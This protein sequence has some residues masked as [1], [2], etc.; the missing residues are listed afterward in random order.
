MSDVYKKRFEAVF[1]CKHPRGP[2]MSCDVA[3]KYIKKSRAFVE[4]WVNRFKVSKNVDDLRDRGSVGKVTQKDEKKIVTLFSRNP[5]L[6]LRQGQ[7][8]LKQKGLDISHVTLRAHLRA[9][10]LK[11]RST[12]KKPLLSEKHTA[13]RLAW[14]QENIDRDWSNVIFS[15]EASVW[16]YVIIPRAWCSSAK[17]FVQRTVKHPIKVHLWGCFSKKGFGVLLLFTNNLNAPRM[18]EIYKKS[19]LPTAKRQ[20]SKKNEEWILQEDNDPKHR[21]R[22]CTGWKQENGIITLDWAS[23]SPDANPIENVWAYIKQKIRGKRLFTLK[24]LS[25]EIRRVWKALPLEY[26]ENL[27]ESMQRR[28]QAIIDAGGDWTP[29]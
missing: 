1:L 13:K 27:V 25:R 19:L 20:F 21:S 6:S 22:L 24:Q 16:G 3:A 5:G 26:A 15:D 17:Q 7:A 12:L 23:Q 14:A 4:K 10:N 11:W 8:K 28:C 29:Y 9:N 2:K 18:V